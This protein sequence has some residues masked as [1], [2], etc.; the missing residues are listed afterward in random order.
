MLYIYAYILIYYNL[1]EIARNF[2]LSQ[3]DI[4]FHTEKMST[5]E[6][7]NIII[8]MN[9][10]VVYLYLIFIIKELLHYNYSHSYQ[11]GRAHV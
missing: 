9:F 4:T 7:Y 11:I 8:Y 2:Y 3:F 10:F 5:L 1:E 6:N